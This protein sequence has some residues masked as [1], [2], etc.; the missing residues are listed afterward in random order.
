M[1][2]RTQYGRIGS[3]VAATM[4]AC[5]TMNGTGTAIAVAIQKLGATGSGIVAAGSRGCTGRR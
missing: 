1:L 5:C 4:G 3:G 2:G